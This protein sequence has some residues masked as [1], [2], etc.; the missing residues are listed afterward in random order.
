MP[1]RTFDAAGTG[2]DPYRR[3]SASQTNL[4]TSCPRKWFYAYRHGLKGPMPPVIIRGN[5]AE[6]CLSRI[7]QESPVL[8]A[9][10]STTLL[11]SPLT[12]DKDPDYDDT[13]NWLASRLD[14]RPEGDWPDSREALEARA[15]SPLDLHSYPCSVSAVHT[16]KIPYTPSVR[17]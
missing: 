5:A 17:F 3:L 10:D 1:V 2:I 15:P 8:I 9:P 4:W 16:L 6:S 14:A 12:A 7:M 11:T 13:T